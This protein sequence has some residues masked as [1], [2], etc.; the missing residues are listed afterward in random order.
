[1]I[2]VKRPNITDW[3]NPDYEA[4]YRFRNWNLT[5]LRDGGEDAWEAAWTYYA[6][7]PCEAINDWVTTYDPRLVN[8]GINPYVPFQLFPRQRECVDWLWDLYL[9]QKEG[10]LEKSRDCGATW[11]AASF[12]WWL[13]TFHEGVQ[14]GF[15]SR[16]EGLVDRI[17]DPDSIFEKIRILIARLPVELRPADWKSSEDQPYMRIKNRETSSVMIGQGGRNIGRGGR[18]SLYFVD[19][20]AFLEYPEEAQ[21]ALS[22]NADAKIWLSTPNGTGNPFFRMRFSGNFPVFTFHWRDDPRKDQAWYD[23]KKRTLEPEVLAQE[24]DLDY[25]ASD[26]QV[27]IPSIH[28]RASRTLRKALEKDG[29]LPALVKG[30]GVAGL[31]VGAGGPGKSVLVPRFGPIVKSSTKWGDDDTIDIAAKARACAIEQDCN[32][33]KF[34]SIGVGRG[35]AAA[36]RRMS[37][38]ISQG[39]NVGDRPT[40]TRWPDGKRAKDKFVN[41]KAELW[42][43]VRD[44]LRRTY[45]HWLHYAGEGGVAHDVQDLLFLPDDDALCAELSLPRYHHTEA[46]KIQ[47]ESKRQLAARG[48]ASPDHAEALVLTYAPRVTV[49]GA[50]R[51]KARW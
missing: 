17:G 25:E 34:D 8:R 7:H 47:I 40:R 32:I 12:S 14:I 27:C 36:L 44:A 49:K 30:S 16:K 51:A 1:M 39:V 24:V 26:T 19:E 33:V 29:L 42:W 15:G 22:A 46:G 31:D 9:T 18:S 41:L 20:A 11:V 28:V 37:G 13:W 38:V 21:A 50:A 45:E 43:N 10:V 23:E 2:R 6:A 48:V 5:R 35:V 4:I 3:K